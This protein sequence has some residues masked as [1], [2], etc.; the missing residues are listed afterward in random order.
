MPTR[1]SKATWNGDL[2]NGKGNMSFGSG[3]YK[4][5]YSFKSRFEDGTGT[6]PEELIGAALAG[7][8]SMALSGDLA[9]AGYAPEAV[10]T[11]A[12]VALEMVDG[13]PAITTITLNVTGNISD[14][15]KDEFLEL[16]EG[17]K[18]NCPVSKALAGVNI[19]LNATLDN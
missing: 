14:I 18:K 15:E 3:A 17:A 1:K 9:E 8:F 5:S 4:G 13:D 7:C 2:K 10:T 12:D 16:A 11:N 6:N 19:K